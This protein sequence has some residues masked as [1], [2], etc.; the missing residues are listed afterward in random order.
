MTEYAA[1]EQYRDMLDEVYGTV[2][3]ADIEYD[4]SRTLEAI[5]ETAFRCGFSDWLDSEGIEL[6]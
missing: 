2:T 3:I 4:T 1:L 5:D 6:E